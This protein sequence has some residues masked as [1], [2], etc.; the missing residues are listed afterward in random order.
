M[1]AW[2]LTAFRIFT[3]VP[4]SQLKT[5][6]PFCLQTAC[7]N[8]LAFGILGALVPE[9]P[10]NTQTQSAQIPHI[11]WHHRMYIEPTYIYDFTS[12]PGT[13]SS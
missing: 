10:L 9:T 8:T 5:I 3:G 6:P 2:I 4:C 13:H 11:K 12:Y 7:I 1:A